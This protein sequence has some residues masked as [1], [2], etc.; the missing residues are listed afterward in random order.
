[1]TKI[2][3]NDSYVLIETEDIDFSMLRSAIN[4]LAKTRYRFHDKVFHEPYAPYYDSYLGQTFV[5][6]HASAEDETGNHVWLTCISDENI[7]VS[8]YIYLEQLVI[9]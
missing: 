2:T 6:D 5:I 8:R 9:E 7:K 4:M 3:S 1:M